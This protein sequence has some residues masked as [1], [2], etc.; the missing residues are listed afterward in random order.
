MAQQTA[1]A[2]FPLGGWLG[3]AWYGMFP[4]VPSTLLLMST[5]GGLMLAATTFAA[6]AGVVSDPIQRKLGL[7][8]ARLLR[9]IAALEAQMFDKSAAGFTVHDHYVARLLDLFDLVGAALR[10]TRP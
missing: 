1:V 2:S 6:V 3:G 8:R 9:L 10:L 4:A 7:H 5:T